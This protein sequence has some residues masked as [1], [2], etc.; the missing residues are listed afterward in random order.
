M[1]AASVS[2][3]A[4][5]ERTVFRVLEEAA[6]KYGSAP[7]LNQPFT[8]EGKRKYRTLNWIEYR[9]AAEEIAAGLR[10]LDV[11]KGDIVALNSETRLE[12]YLADLGIMANGSIAAAMY[13]S[14]PAPDLVG[15]IES[16]GAKAVFVENPKT[17]QALRNARVPLSYLLTGEA[18]GAVPLAA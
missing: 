14:Y 15:A 16:A 10:T 2:I 11:Q 4:M 5:P 6:E 17:L 9:Q 12:F 8:E 1:A 3:V 13:P 18:E 7:A